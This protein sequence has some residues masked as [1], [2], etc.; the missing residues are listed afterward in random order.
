MEMGFDVIAVSR[1]H[2]KVEGNSIDLPFILMKLANTAENRN[3]FTKPGLMLI[4]VE[5]KEARTSIR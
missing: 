2:K 4:R 3:I 5:P 1:F